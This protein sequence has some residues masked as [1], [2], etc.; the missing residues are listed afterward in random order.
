MRARIARHGNEVERQ[1]DLRVGELAQRLRVECSCFGAGEETIAR[2]GKTRQ[3]LGVLRWGERRRRLHNRSLLS[4]TWRAS[5]QATQK[6]T[7]RLGG[8]ALV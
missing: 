4:G 2:L 5:A 8:T 1:A 7:D 6:A 3:Q